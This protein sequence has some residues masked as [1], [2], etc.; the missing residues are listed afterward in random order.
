MVS[1]RVS[2]TLLM[3]G[4]AFVSVG[5][6][7]LA[8]LVPLRMQ[9][10][11][12]PPL[13]IGIVAT[14]YTTGFLLGSLI[15]P[16]LIRAVG[17]IRA[18]AVCAGISLSLTLAFPLV[19][20]WIPW[21]GL[22]LGNG[23]FLAGCF[24][25]IESWI[26]DRAPPERRG[27]AFSLYIMSNRLSYG[28]GQLL[29]MVGDPTG[30]GL[31]MTIAALLGMCLVPIAMNKGESPTPSERRGMGFFRLFGISPL[32]A[33]GA[34]TAGLMNG[35]VNNLGPVYALGIGMTINQIAIFTAAVQAGNVLLQYPIGRWSDVGD[36]RRILLVVSLVACVT[37]LVLGLFHS[38]PFPVMVALAAL[39][40]GMTL[41]LYPLCIAYATDRS[42]RA[43]IVAVNG[44]MMLSWGTGASVG[45]FIGT[46]AM[47]LAGVGGLFLYAALCAACLSAYCVW[48][49]TRRPPPVRHNSELRP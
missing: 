11:G 43:Q 10:E 35:A 31:F 27:R 20:H 15:M 28:V 46:F 12:F 7:V 23:I 18:F 33:I 17:H 38:L 5:N 36:R 32:A 1:F 25:V 34:V 26:N 41:C 44:G 6:G 30:P 42:E 3:T 45:P 4:A 47:Q 40:G 22:R 39:L 16:R 37:C 49:M 9:M 8:N 2:L 13:A 29:L 21:T 14:A 19:V 48:R 24:L